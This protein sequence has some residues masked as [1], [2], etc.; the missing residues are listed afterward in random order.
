MHSLRIAARF[1]LM[2]TLALLLVATTA[3]CHRD[4]KS[5]ILGKWKQIGGN[6]T[7]QFF[8]DGTFAINSAAGNYVA[9]YSL[10]DGE[11]LRVEFSGFEAVGGIQLW[12]MK[13]S[14]DSLTL[15]LPEDKTATYQRA[16]SVRLTISS[17]WLA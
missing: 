13:V 16:H 5:A 2:T 9:K 12:G 3:S 6:E 17:R 8:P 11:H 4:P 1:A 14:S 10:P 15:M 7:L